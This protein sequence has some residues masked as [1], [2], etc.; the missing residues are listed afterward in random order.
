MQICILPKLSAHTFRPALNLWGPPWILE[1]CPK[2]LICPHLSSTIKARIPWLPCWLGYQAVSQLFPHLTEVVKAAATLPWSPVFVDGTYGDHPRTI[3][4][5]WVSSC[6]W[7]AFCSFGTLHLCHSAS[8]PYGR[9][10]QVFA[11]VLTAPGWRVTK[12]VH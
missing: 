6:V 9:Q 4:W 10:Q 1:T 5:G 8:S 12:G 2:L 11:Y 3:P 7:G